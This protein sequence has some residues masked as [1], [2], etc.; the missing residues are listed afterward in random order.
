MST[1]CR[2]AGLQ[3]SDRLLPGHCRLAAFQYLGRPTRPVGVLPLLEPLGDLGRH[4]STDSPTVTSEVHHPAVADLGVNQLGQ[5][6]SGVGH[7][8]LDSIVRAAGLRSSHVQKVHVGRDFSQKLS[9]DQAAQPNSVS[10]SRVSAS[11][12]ICESTEI[13]YHVFE[14]GLVE[15]SIGDGEFDL[16]ATERGLCNLVTHAQAALRAVA[17]NDEGCPTA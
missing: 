7:G 8:Y 9:N 11:V 3:F 16:L 13:N 4:H 14:R 6:A 2:I 15:F 10:K 5:P 17:R 12:R 1:G